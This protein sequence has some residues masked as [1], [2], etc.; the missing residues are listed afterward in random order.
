MILTIFAE[1]AFEAP[2][3]RRIFSSSPRDPRYHMLSY[4]SNKFTQSPKASAHEPRAALFLNRFT[5][6]STI[7][8]ATNGVSA[9]LGILPE[10]LIAKSFY[11]CIAENCLQ[12]AV[13]CLESAKAN[14]SIAYL[15]FWFRRPS[16]DDDGGV[17][18]VEM[19]DLPHDSEEDEDEGGVNLESQRSRHGSGNRTHLHTSQSASSSSRQNG[20]HNGGNGEVTSGSSSGHSADVNNQHMSEAVFDRPAI[21]PRSSAS[22]L[23]PQHEGPTANDTV[24][25]EA[26]VSCTSDG[27][28]VIL[29]KARPLIPQPPE[30][31]APTYSNG[32]FASPWATNPVIPQPTDL[33]SAYPGTNSSVSGNNGPSTATTASFGPQADTFMSAI[34]DVAVFAWSLTGINGSLVQHGRGKP[35]GESQPPGGLPVWDPASHADPENRFNGFADNSHRRM[36]RL[37]QERFRGDESSSSDDVVVW[38]RAP[39]IPPWRPAFHAGHQLE[40]FRGHRE[41]SNDADNSSSQNQGGR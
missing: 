25:V 1:R 24:E 9:I 36:P 18:D 15:R 3:V 13:R 21:P 8:F 40:P 34:R 37:P 6:T 23:V 33:I 17:G 20:F 16:Q 19:P 11:F 12:D 10:Q 22:S 27:L 28:V 30:E 35:S 41:P 4:L 31:P 39:E 5:R 38:R 29:R 14:D 2:V 7:M 32:L 26:V